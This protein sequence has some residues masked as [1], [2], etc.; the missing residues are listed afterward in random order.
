VRLPESHFVARTMRA[1]ELLALHPLSAPQVAEAL[2]IHP[3]T[4]RRLLTRLTEDGWLSRSEDTRRV[5]APTL[6]I[7]S[8][9][10]HV[11]ERCA[12]AEAARPY[13]RALREEFGAPAH[14]MVPSYRWV[15]CILHDADGEPLAG[16]HELAPCHATAAGKALLAWREPWREVVLEQRLEAFTDR[17]T[18]G[19]EALRRELARTVVRGYAVEDRE[20]E[21]DTRGVA[22][23]VFDDSGDAV[24]AIAVAA[25]VG[26]LPAERYGDIGAAVT[27][28]A[29]GL[30]AKLGFVPPAEAHDSPGVQARAA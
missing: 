28:A 27:G 5:Y 22:A 17:T 19:P 30:S 11:V 2:D 20:H 6:R 1:L 12:V 15:L 21:P 23:P 7:A 26:R 9:A 14:L 13:V 18:V 3:R 29:A 8:L 24:A 4:A 10:G 16:L 25:P